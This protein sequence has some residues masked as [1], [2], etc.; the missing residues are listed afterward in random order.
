MMRIKKNDTV[1][2]LSGKDKG[3]KG[4]VINVSPK[5]DEA[6]VKGVGLCTKH[7][8]ARKQGEASTIK[9][10]ESYIDMNKLMPICSSC[11]KPCRVGVKILETGKRQRVCK[12]CNEVMA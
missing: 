4:V 12:K 10:I 3:K 8:K 6:L 7:M 5:K 2:V 11:K 1:I 9:S